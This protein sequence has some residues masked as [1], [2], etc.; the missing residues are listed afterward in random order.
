MS[1]KIRR[2]LSGCNDPPKSATKNG[3]PRNVHAINQQHAIQARARPDVRAKGL[4]AGA[5]FAGG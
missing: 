2:I 3:L 1:A 5:A 4:L